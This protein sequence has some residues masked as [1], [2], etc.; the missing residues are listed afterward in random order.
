MANSSRVIRRRKTDTP[1]HQQKCHLYLT[2]STEDLAAYSSYWVYIKNLGSLC[3][4]G[5]IMLEKRLYYICLKMTDLDNMSQR[6]IQ[7]LK[8]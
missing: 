4:W 3:S 8:S 1:R 5:W 6:Y 7:H 2:G